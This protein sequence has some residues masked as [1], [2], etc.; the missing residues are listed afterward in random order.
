MVTENDALADIIAAVQDRSARG[1]AAAINRLVSSGRLPPGLRLPTVRALAR[2]LGVSP[3]TVSYAWQSLV[4]AGAVIALGRKG[5]FVTSV[6]TAD[7]AQRTLRT[8]ESPGGLTLDLSTGIPD[9]AL[10]PD[11]GRALSRVRSTCS[12]TS[13]VERPVLPELEAIL[14]ERWP[15]IPEALT[16]VSGALDALD[17][18]TSQLVRMGD[19][20]LVEN[21]CF[22]P[23][24]DLLEVAGAEPIGLPLDDEGPQLDAVRSA[25]DAQP[26]AFYLQSRAHNP[27]GVSLSPARAR[28]IGRLLRGTAVRVIEDDH[29]GE[30]S[31]SAL[32]SIGTSLPSQ[33]IHIRSFSKSHGPDLRM[34]AVGG[35]GDIIDGLNYRRLL[36]PGWS[37]RLLQAVLVELLTDD[38]SE[39]SVAE[40]REVY[41]ERR[42]HMEKLLREREVVAGGG[43]GI[44]LWVEV[45][46][47]QRALV[48]LAAAG[49]GV[50]PGTPFL[51]D[52]LDSD[53]VRLT[54]GLV[55][56]GQAESV[57]DALSLAGGGPSWSASG[58]NGRGRRAAPYR[59]ALR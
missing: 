27:T 29:A 34:A 23:L 43:D 50:A 57:A 52:P 15:F 56:D 24:L 51:T 19:C 49:I 53:H 42:M 54:V 21:P 55:Q 47:E 59:G 37:S 28:Q 48:V 11:L 45:P 40:A 7:G 33:T 10:L 12:T 9:P 58:T 17:R 13:Y 31:S 2:G 44:N 30:I 16:V 22:P 14:R 38:A 6:H 36:G 4:R 41:R 26:V 46:G 32:A 5:T 8:Y 18:L 3:T 20:V 25:L 35:A 39:A 1:I